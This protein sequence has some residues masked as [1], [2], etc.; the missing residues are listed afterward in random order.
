MTLQNRFHFKV[1][2]FLVLSPFFLYSEANMLRDMALTMGAQF[3]GSIA[4]QQVTL[5]FENMTEAL[6]QTQTNIATQTNTFAGLVQQAQAKQLKHS[7]YFLQQ[8]QNNI[9]QLLANQQKDFQA[10]LN[11]VQ[12]TVSRVPPATEYLQDTI[13]FDQAFADATMYTPKGLVWKNVYP[14][15]N[16]EYDET[17]DSFWQMNAMP[18]MSTNSAGVSSADKAINNAIFAEWITRELSYEILCEINL[19]EAEY[20]FFAGLIFNKA[21]WI[22]G[23]PTCLQKYRLLGLYATA[24]NQIV[25]SFAEAVSTSAAQENQLPTWNFPFAQIIEQSAVHEV[26]ITVPAHL[27]QSI[28]SRHAIVYLKVLVAPGQIQC[29]F[30]ALPDQEPATYTTLVSQN[31]ELFLYHGIGFMAPGCLAQFKL[32]KPDQVLFAPAMRDQFTAQVSAMVQDALIKQSTQTI[33]QMAR[34]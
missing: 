29:K 32:L 23:D 4:N 9:N 11:Y 27:G 15:G 33:D 14:V 25:L 28:A 13:S 34:G 31:P 3:A 6:T 17:T 10:M 22:S 2:I 21:R 19:Y 24:Q 30:W 12:A 20:P 18:M 16:W 5:E 7:F 26:K 8:A 1:L